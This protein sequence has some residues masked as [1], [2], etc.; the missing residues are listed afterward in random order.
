MGASELT[1]VISY[2]AFKADKGRIDP[3]VADIVDAL[4][5]LG[6]AAHRDDVANR[7]VRGRAGRDVRATEAER[8]EVFSAFKTYMSTATRRRHAPLLH[9]PLGPDTY[10]WALTE[11]CKTRLAQHT[12]VDIAGTGR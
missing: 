2:V 3:A 12:A 7:V 4:R 11:A 9:T 10:R 5:A 8:D 1:N 6:G